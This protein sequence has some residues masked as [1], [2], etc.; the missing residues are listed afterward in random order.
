MAELQ[1]PTDPRDLPQPPPP[2]AQR[3]RLVALVQ[4]GLLTAL[5]GAGL[6]LVLAGAPG[7]NWLLVGIGAYLLLTALLGTWLVISGKRERAHYTPLVAALIAHGT[8]YTGEVTATEDAGGGGDSTVK[9]TVTV[10]HPG[11]PT[12]LTRPFSPVHIPRVGDP[13][14]VLRT[15]DSTAL[16]FPGDRDPH[17]ELHRQLKAAKA[18][19]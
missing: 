4:Y 3:R 11:G 13:V 16:L 18:G 7:T 17:P 14:L 5:F 19:R 10:T 9:V 12:T 8:R 1:L 6:A 15:P 2:S